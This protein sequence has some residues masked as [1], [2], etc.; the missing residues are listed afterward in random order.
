V[1]VDPGVDAPADVLCRPTPRQRNRG[2][3]EPDLQF[4]HQRDAVAVGQADV[5]DDQ[6]NFGP[7]GVRV[8][9][10]GTRPGAAITSQR[11]VPLASQH[12]AQH[13]QR[14]KVVVDDENRATA[15]RGT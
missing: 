11:R 7:R 5:A 2:A 10:G 3:T 8:G 9:G 1:P 13:V 12:Q 4:A 6:V 15:R 14:V